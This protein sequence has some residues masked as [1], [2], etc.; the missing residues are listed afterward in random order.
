[1]QKSKEIGGCLVLVSVQDSVDSMAAASSSWELVKVHPFVFLV[2]TIS[3]TRGDPLVT[4]AAAS[5][6]LVPLLVDPWV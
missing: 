6:F 4:T 5:P 1:M 2:V 3:G